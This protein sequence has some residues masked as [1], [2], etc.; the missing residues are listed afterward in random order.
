[1]TKQELALLSAQRLDIRPV[2]NMNN[3]FIPGIQKS[4]RTAYRYRKY[5]ESIGVLKATRGNFTLNTTA[6]AQSSLFP[7]LL[8]SLNALKKGRRFGRR[9]N[10]SDIEF[11]EQHIDH[12]LITLDYKVW[13][14]TKYQYPSDLYV[15]VNNINKIAEYLK[16]NKFKEG[17]KG[18]IIIIPMIGDF[19]NE[20]QRVYLDCIAKGGRSVQD[21]IAIGL[22]Y[23]DRLEFRGQFDIGE[24]KNVQE[25]LNMSEHD[26]SE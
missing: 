19:T 18:P 14:L 12:H 16:K 17:K 26:I 2:Y 25:N 3:D 5:L 21:A 13:E 1:M 10:Q 11:V 9:Y 15:Y 8:P 7:K 22:L 24:I 6:I 23:G 20:I 4:R